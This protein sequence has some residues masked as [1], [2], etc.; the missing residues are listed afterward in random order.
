MND[1]LSPRDLAPHI[2]YTLVRTGVTQEEITAL[3]EAC[4]TY[5][6]NAAMLPGCWVEHGKRL[7]AGTSVKVASTVDFPYGIMSTQG[8][9]A[10]AAS[11]VAAG[12]DEL[13][14]AVNIGFLKSGMDAAFKADIAAVVAAAAGRPVKVMLELPLLTPDERERV[15]D[16]AVSAGARF[17]KNASSGAI[18]TA[19]PEDMRYLRTRAPQG[20]GV[21]GSGGIR[22]R[23]Q[24]IALLEAGADLVG[25]SSAISIVTGTEDPQTTAY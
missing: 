17:L 24:V 9:V 19:T 15:V 18:G 11:L 20:V 14:I 5:G 21:K 8:K 13:D 4:V 6:F 7:L 10:E 23:A 2:Q 3:C 22:T 25:T 1:L 16:L 12:V